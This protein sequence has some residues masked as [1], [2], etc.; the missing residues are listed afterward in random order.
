MPVASA[1]SVGREYRRRKAAPVRALDDLSF[2]VNP[3]EYVALLGPNGAGKSTLLRLL[4]GLDR[5]DTGDVHTPPRADLAVVFQRPALDPLLTIRENLRL[6]AAL[7]NVPDAAA[8]AAERLGLTDRLNDRVATLSGGLARRADLARA[9]LTQPKLLLLDE[10]TTGLDHEARAAFLDTL[11]AQR[12]AD[13]ALAIVLST[14]LMDEAARATRVVMIDHGRTVADGPPDDLRG[15]LGGD[16]LL[17]TATDH[18][19][20]LERCGLTITPDGAHVRA[21]G[22][23]SVLAAAAAELTTAGAS[24]ELAPPTLGD[25]YLARAGRGLS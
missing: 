2:S 6:Q 12:A 11:D 18:T 16:R 24:F 19:A 13:P 15:T 1:A 20:L 23:D 21:H 25:V 9:L 3:G 14:H 17:R 8:A 4:A 5:P 7:Y 22:D 10:P